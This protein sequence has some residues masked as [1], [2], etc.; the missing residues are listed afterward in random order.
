MM[1]DVA[2]DRRWR[3]YLRDGGC[4][5]YCGRALRAEEIHLDHDQPGAREE[6]L[7]LEHLACACGD[8]RSEKGDRTG[9][10]Y[11]SFR[12]VRHAHEMLHHLAGRGR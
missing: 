2:A 1:T 4:C 5:T 7:A 10:E 9:V 3:V 8:C 6:D 11:R 12:R